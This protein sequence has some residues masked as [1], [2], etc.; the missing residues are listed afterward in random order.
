[1]P[2]KPIEEQELPNWEDVQFNGVKFAPVEGV[3][4]RFNYRKLFAKIGQKTATGRKISQHDVFRTLVLEDLWGLVYFGMK[5]DIANHPFWVQACRDVQ[6]GPQDY[7][8]DVWARG[9]G[10]STI[11]TTARNIQRVLANP[12]LTIGIF[13]HTREA[14]LGFLRGIKYILESNEALQNA[15]PD[16]LYKEPAKEAW[17]WAEES[18]LYVKRTTNKREA[19][20]EAWGLVEGMPTGKHFDHRTYDDIVTQ[21]LV[22]SPELIQKVKDSFDMSMNLGSLNGTHEVIGTFYHHEDPLVYIKNKKDL[23]GNPIYTIRKKAATD[24]GTPS[25]KAVFKTDE[26]LNKDKGN[27]QMFYSQQLLD[28]TPRGTEQLKWEYVKQG[29]EQDKLPSRLYKFMMIDPA[30]T[31]K[32][33]KNGDAWAMIV[34]GVEPVLDDIGA[35]NIYILDAVIEPMDLDVAIDEAVAMYMRHGRIHKLGIEKV[36]MMTAEIHIANALRVQGRHVSVENG[37]LY[38]LRPGGRKKNTRIEQNLSWPL[39][40][41]KI[42]ICTSVPTAGRERLKTEMEKFPYWHDDGLDALAY[43]FDML[44]DFRF[45]KRH[46]EDEK[47][48]ESELMKNYFS[49]HSSHRGSSVRSWMVV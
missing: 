2:V 34:V 36:G 4:Y 41:S 26:Q 10:K 20:F 35:S 21:D 43:G 46:V 17:K 6:D 31:K 25:G 47:K 37:G 32:D 27:L 28:P 48:D 18:G 44:K 45:P 5:V 3:K 1:M 16:V 39:R 40:N 19:T 7:T 42:H 24:D 12:E 30:G 15:F 13:S 9:H 33:A 8:L 11:I 38:I 22:N 29:I 23:D 49:N 14:A